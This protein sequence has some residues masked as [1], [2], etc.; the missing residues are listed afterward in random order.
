M[1]IISKK[2]SF[3][4]YL[5]NCM[6]NYMFGSD[7]THILIFFTTTSRNSVKYENSIMLS[8]YKLTKSFSFF[9]GHYV[10]FG[11]PP[12]EVFKYSQA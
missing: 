11:W 4:F 7:I 9:Y 12:Y 1:P 2:I 6:Q 5:Q 3:D 8:S 10:T